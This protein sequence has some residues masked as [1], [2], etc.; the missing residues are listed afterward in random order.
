MALDGLSHLQFE[1][2]RRRRRRGRGSHPCTTATWC[3]LCCRHCP[4]AGQLSLCLPAALSCVRPT[5]PNSSTLFTVMLTSLG[6][7]GTAVRRSHRHQVHV[8][9]VRRVH[10]LES[11]GP[12]CQQVAHRSAALAVKAGNGQRRSCIVPDVRDL[13]ALGVHSGHRPSYLV[14]GF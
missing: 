9:P 1:G 5:L 14:Y 3:P 8:V 13:E 7:A 12:S 4:S 6:L 11:W 2:Q 10:G